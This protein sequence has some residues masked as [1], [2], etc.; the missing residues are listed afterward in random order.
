[1]FFEK[2]HL[3]IDLKLIIK[4][5]GQW[6]KAYKVVSSIFGIILELFNVL[7]WGIGEIFN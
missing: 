2:F 4:V 1:M 7:V 3:P 5:E 6:L